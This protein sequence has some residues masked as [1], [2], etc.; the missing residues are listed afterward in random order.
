MAIVIIII[1]VAFIAIVALVAITEL[2]CADW[3]TI[4]A[5][6]NKTWVRQ[7]CHNVT[8]KRDQLSKIAW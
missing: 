5:I 1:I 3:I 4:S 8:K 6:L 2:Y 7:Q